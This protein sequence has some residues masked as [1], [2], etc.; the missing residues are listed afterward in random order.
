ML[1]GTPVIATNIYGGRVPVTVSGMGRLVEP[2]NPKE[3]ANA[4]LKIASNKT[5]YTKKRSSIL[6]IFPV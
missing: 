5:S 3:L 6:K 2:E 4:I 1:S